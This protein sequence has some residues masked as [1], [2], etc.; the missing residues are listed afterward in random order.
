[1]PAPA[2]L[3]ELD[4]HMSGTTWAPI[5]ID[6]HETDDLADINGHSWAMGL[7]WHLPVSMRC[8]EYLA[9]LGGRG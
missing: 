2:H 6:Y 5:R 9:P 4:L 8:A 1:M 7:V 3:G